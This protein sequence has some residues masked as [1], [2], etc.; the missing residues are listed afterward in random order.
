[1]QE[2]KEK[3]EVLTT[4]KIM[5]MYKGGRRDF[6]NVRCIGGLFSGVNLSDTNFRSSNLSFSD[7]SNANLS[8]TD[9]TK[10]NMCWSDFENA[11]FRNS[12]LN[13]TN[14][15]WCAFINTKFEG[16]DVSWS[17]FSWCLLIN[18]NLGSTEQKGARFGNVARSWEEITDYGMQLALKFLNDAKIP[19]KLK[20][21]LN[22]IVDEK[23]KEYRVMKDVAIAL[24]ENITKSLIIYEPP[25]LSSAL[26]NVYIK[27]GMG[28][29]SKYSE[30]QMTLGIH[31]YSS[32]SPYVLGSPYSQFSLYRGISK[33]NGFR[34][35]N[36]V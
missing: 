30:H 10:A 17:D 32:G 25:I 24:G 2:I 27:V 12:K 3:T 31:L 33:Y 5:K 14:L 36:Y 7:F 18:I 22:S 23:Q 4:A 6:S 20:S 21:I 28:S 13:N 9:F 16:A 11:N 35:Q 8:N 34:G 26:P 1:M 29:L 19:S 15:S